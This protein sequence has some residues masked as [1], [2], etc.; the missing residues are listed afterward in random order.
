ML[1]MGALADAQYAATALG[2]EDRNGSEDGQP[3]REY[4]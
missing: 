1:L 3:T 4:N 2:W